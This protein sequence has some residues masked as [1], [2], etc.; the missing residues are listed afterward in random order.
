MIEPLFPPGAAL[1]GPEAGLR[2]ATTLQGTHLTTRCDSSETDPGVTVPGD[3]ASGA[4]P[5]NNPTRTAD[6][7]ADL[8]ETDGLPNGTRVRYFGDYELTCELGR[9]G[10]GVV[11]KA[12]QVSLNR[13]VALKW[14]SQPPLRP[15]TS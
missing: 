13:S 6:F 14:S 4:G 2:S 9:G 8:N 12:R 10:M 1:L 11:Y 7:D 15:R 3:S 5:T